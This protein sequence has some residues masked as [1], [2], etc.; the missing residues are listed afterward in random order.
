[1]MKMSKTGL[2]LVF[3]LLSAGC[4]GTVREMPPIPEALLTPRE[5]PTWQGETNGDLLG[6]VL[7]L[8]EALG[9]C[10]ADRAAIKKLLGETGTR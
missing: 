8:K 6:Y 9:R 10:A 2:P 1:M 5:T 4:S 3:L 7:E